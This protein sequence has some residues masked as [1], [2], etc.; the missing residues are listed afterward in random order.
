MPGFDLNSEVANISDNCV[1]TVSCSLYYELD[2]DYYVEKEVP[3]G[4]AAELCFGTFACICPSNQYYRIA[5]NMP[6]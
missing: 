3:C 6:N 1:D 5:Q 2:W 4:S